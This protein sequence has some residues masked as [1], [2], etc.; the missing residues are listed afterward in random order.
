MPMNLKPPLAVLLAALM[1]SGCGVIAGGVAGGVAGSELAEDDDEFD[2]LERTEA[3]E[4]VEEAL[5]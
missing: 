5:E 3:A 2:P 4:E 1:L